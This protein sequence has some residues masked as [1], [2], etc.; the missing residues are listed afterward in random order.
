MPTLEE[1][2]QPGKQ[3]ILAVVAQLLTEFAAPKARIDELRWCLRVAN[4][5]SQG[6]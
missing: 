6:K 1:L 2:A 3:A 4:E 5:V